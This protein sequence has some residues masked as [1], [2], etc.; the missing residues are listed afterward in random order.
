M[1]IATFDGQYF[2]K[3]SDA[4]VNT[5]FKPLAGRTA[6]GYY[7]HKKGKV[8]FYKPNGT[9]F[10]AYVKTS[11]FDGIVSAH[12]IE[13]KARFMLALCS[14]D[15]TA[16]GLDINSHKQHKAFANSLENFIK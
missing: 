3:G 4:I 16:L 10:A 8:L 15:A 14:L 9:L 13:G 11:K 6:S 12:I 7:E 2:V 5:L 1:T